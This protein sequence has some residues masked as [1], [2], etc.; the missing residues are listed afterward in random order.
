MIS[1]TMLSNLLALFLTALEI[2]QINHIASDLS[3]LLC[4][5][6]VPLGFFL[7][8]NKIKTINVTKRMSR[9]LQSPMLS[10]FVFRK[11]EVG[12]VVLGFPV[13][14]ELR[15]SSQRVT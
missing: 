15:I 11:S 14:L 5:V 4:E 8:K 9:C 12:T 3:C 7:C 6:I 10:L 2:K 1:H 13:V